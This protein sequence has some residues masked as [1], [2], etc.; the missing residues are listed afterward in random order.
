MN[1]LL[2]PLLTLVVFVSACTKKQSTI[3]PPPVIDTV[4][5]DT[6]KLA[7][8]TTVLV[9]G[10][11][12]VRVESWSEITVPIKVL[13]VNGPGQKVSMM[14]KGLPENISAEWSAETGY[15]NF[16][17]ILTLNT[18]F[19]EPGSYPVT[20][21]CLTE[22]GLSKEYDITLVV[23]SIPKGDCNNLFSS[24]VIT[25]TFILTDAVLDTVVN[26]P[27]VYIY[28]NL[29]KREL[30]LNNIYLSFGADFTQQ[31]GY[32]G[33]NGNEQLAISFDCNTGT[34]IMP[35]QEVEGARFSN[36]DLKKIK[37]SGI[38]RFNPDT[39]L[40]E[41]T[42]MSEYDEG[43]TAIVKTFGLKAQLSK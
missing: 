3:I 30:F 40:L 14:I 21:L 7:L 6:S 42:Y 43:G 31:F 18:E 36:G 16:T 19:V 8:D 23:D 4:Y 10:V 35:E 1:K 17:T 32:I 9:S 22:K 41:L 2:Y 29:S 5:I 33:A 34:V 20:I 11:S 12:D 39:D 27:G 13:H 25:N 37:I 28:H 38:G 15:T 24:A 26:M